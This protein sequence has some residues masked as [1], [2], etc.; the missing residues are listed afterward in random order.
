MRLRLA[1]FAALLASCAATSNPDDV[2]PASPAPAS[3]AQT[4]ST[5]APAAPDPQK[6]PSPGASD[7]EPQPQPEAQDESAAKPDASADAPQ[8]AVGS[9]GGEAI[10][11]SEFFARLW[12]RDSE[13]AREVFEYLVMSQITV[14]EADRLGLRLDP[15]LADATVEKAWK[16]LQDR[17]ESKGSKLT[18]D[19]H[20]ERTLE[21]DHADYERK[22]RADAIVQLL[23]ERCV[24]AWYLSNPRVELRLME[25]TDEAALTAAQA[26]LDAG[27]PFEDVARAHGAD[28]DAQSGGTRMTV[29]RSESSELARLA[30]STDVGAIGGPLVQA[31]RFLLIRPEMRHEAIE[32]SWS[33]V[34][35]AVEQSL[36]ESPIDSDRLEYAQWRAAMVRRY[37]IDLS[38]FLALVR[39]PH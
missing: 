16:A 12:M 35:A 31:G 22:L 37:P 28:T 15:A 36:R 34:G 2:R 1:L 19:Q 29:V 11:A 20:I 9:V 5:K 4:S 26:E 38:R 7:Q 23:T 6:T 33:E 13:R 32:G 8:L 21:M 39:G 25:L 18:I 30:F 27:K 3:K 10:D 17:L 14:F 24:R